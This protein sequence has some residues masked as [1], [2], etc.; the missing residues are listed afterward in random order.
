L[1][2]SDYA[3]SPEDVTLDTLSNVVIRE[4]CSDGRVG[5]VRFLLLSPA[6][7]ACVGEV[8]R[9]WRARLEPL[10]EDDIYATLTVEEFDPAF[11]RRELAAQIDSAA[12]EIWGVPP[13]EISARLG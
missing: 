1:I 10:S 6:Q 7:R 2:E 13:D 9:Y 4:L 3:P 8:L 11:A 12:R 5:G